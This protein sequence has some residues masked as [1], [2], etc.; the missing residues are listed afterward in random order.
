MATIP[1]IS[2]AIEVAS[3]HAAWLK[4]RSC[5]SRTL[6]DDV[7]AIGYHELERP[8]RRGAYRIRLAAIAAEWLLLPKGANHG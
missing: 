6:A 7:A 2:I 1:E 4:S 3:E 5:R 8:G